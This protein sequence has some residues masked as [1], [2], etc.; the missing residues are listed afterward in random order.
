[1]ASTRNKDTPPFFWGQTVLKRH[2]LAHGLT[3]SPYV[4]TQ[5]QSSV[6]GPEP[7]VWRPQ[8][9]PCKVAP[10]GTAQSLSPAENAGNA[11]AGNAD[12]PCACRE[13]AGGRPYRAILSLQDMVSSLS[14]CSTPSHVWRLAL[15]RTGIVPSPD[16]IFVRSCPLA[17]RFGCLSAG[18]RKGRPDE[19]PTGCNPLDI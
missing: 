6:N 4:Q 13:P 19:S 3:R 1:M 7:P 14:P 17:L 9:N 16:S 11:G 2:C 10:K 18:S 5:K 12:A 15:D 8:L